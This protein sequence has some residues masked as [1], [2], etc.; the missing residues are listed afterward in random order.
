[1]VVEARLPSEE[2]EIDLKNYDS[3]KEG[4]ISLFI[5]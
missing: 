1:M 2:A 3:S 5:K 4:R